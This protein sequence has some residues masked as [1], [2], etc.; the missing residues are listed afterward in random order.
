MQYIQYTQYIQYLQYTVPLW[1]CGVVA[2]WQCGGTVALWIVAFW[3]CGIVALW[4]SGTVALW[5]CGSVALWGGFGIHG[6][7]IFFL[8]AF[9]VF[10]FFQKTFLEKCSRKLGPNR[11]NSL[12]YGVL[13]LVVL[14]GGWR[15]CP[16]WWLAFSNMVKVA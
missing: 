12:P 1:H 3:H 13:G 15:W 9:I 2:L 14:F 11:R 10:S 8:C 6:F 7:L 4:P 5:L 16:I